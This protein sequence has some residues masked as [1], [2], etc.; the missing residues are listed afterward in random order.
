[1]LISK[2]HLALCLFLQSAR[3][4][5]HSMKSSHMNPQDPSTLTATSRFCFSMSANGSTVKLPVFF[6]YVLVSKATFFRYIS[7]RFFVFCAIERVYFAHGVLLIGLSRFS[8]VFSFLSPPWPFPR[9]RQA[10]T[11]HDFF[12]KEVHFKR[13]LL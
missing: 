9:K 5:F 10:G 8:R 4:L 11:K 7:P 13:L 12:H 1:M 6:Q 2:L 3:L